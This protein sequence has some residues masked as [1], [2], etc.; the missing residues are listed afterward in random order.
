MHRPHHPT[1]EE[2]L[3]L[4]PMPRLGL[5]EIV[6]INNLEQAEI[7]LETLLTYDVLGFDTESKPTFVKE[8]ISAGPHI[9]QLSTLHKAYIFQLHDAA[10]TR[11]A[12]QLLTHTKIKKVGFGLAGDHTQIRRKMRIQPQNVLDLNEVF[13]SQGYIKEIGVKSAVALLF[14]Q[15]FLKS[16]KASTSN[17]SNQTLTE[18]QLLYAANDAWAAIKVFHALQGAAV[19][20]Q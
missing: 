8:E 3:N 10:S 13:R 4:S 17:W 11:I 9:V 14:N 15:R 2:I 7:A 18:S 16:K 20:A 5:G 12:S 19:P 1:K 6:L